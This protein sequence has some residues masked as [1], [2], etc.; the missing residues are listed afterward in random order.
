MPSTV[1]APSPASLRAESDLRNGAEILLDT[2]IDSG[3]D[4][5]FGY[6][7]GA[8]L[9]LYDA[10][11][12][13][14]ALRH[15]LRHEQAAVH[16][17]EGYARSTGAVCRFPRALPSTPGN[18]AFRFPAT[19]PAV[20]PFQRVL[21]ESIS[22][23]AVSLE[24]KYT[25]TSGRIYLSGVQALV[26]LMLVQRRRDAAAGLRTAGFVSGYRGSPLGGLDETLWNAEAHLEANNIKFLPGVNEELAAT[27]VWHAA[28][29][30][31]G[32]QRL[33][34]RVRYVVRQGARG[35]PLR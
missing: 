25:A 4:T 13:R 14:P 35:R 5:I 28:G 3:I 18:C 12:S 8:A 17:A 31:H 27:A 19:T 34:R 16:A 22:M 20:K 2:L 6:P 15:V 10:L 11:Y 23:L 21:P 1:L 9:P 26:R 33:R 32:R 7:G 24:D 30:S 29:A